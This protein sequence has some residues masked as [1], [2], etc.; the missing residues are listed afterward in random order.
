[1]NIGVPSRVVCPRSNKLTDSAW[2]GAVIAEVL[3][4]VLSALRSVRFVV[5]VLALSEQSRIWRRF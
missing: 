5:Q 1:V 4:D 3:A 2:P